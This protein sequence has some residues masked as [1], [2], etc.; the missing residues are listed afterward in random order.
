M[1]CLLGL[2]KHLAASLFLLT[3]PVFC[4][5]FLG[6]RGCSRCPHSQH[7]GQEVNKVQ[8]LSGRPQRGLLTSC[9]PEVDHVARLTAMES[10]KLNGLTDGTAAA[11]SKIKVL[12]VWKKGIINRSVGH[13]SVKAKNTNIFPT[14]I[15][16][17]H[18]QCFSLSTDSQW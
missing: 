13:K 3:S 1:Q 14:L 18:Q 12:L 9:W 6:E 2:I 7:K 15:P 10:G 16:P 11:Y 4:S 8:L 5:S 17:S